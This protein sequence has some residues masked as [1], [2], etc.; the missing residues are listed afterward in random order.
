MRLA[1]DLQLSLTAAQIVE[2]FVRELTIAV[3][4]PRAVI[5]GAVLT[6]VRKLFSHQHIDHVEHPVDLL[7]RLRMRRR[8][9]DIQRGHITLAFLDIALGDHAGLHALFDSRLDDLVID[10]GK[11]RNIIHVP[12][13]I[14]K[15]ASERVKKDHG[16]CIPDVDE[17]IDR[18]PADI[19]PHPALL[20]RTKRLLGFCECVVDFDHGSSFPFLYSP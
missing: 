16:T 18:R 19:D 1:G 2:V 20:D 9:Q 15:V 10:I 12:A 7:G 8:R 13:L 11:V 5:D 3:E 6:L 4:L 17:V 14:Q